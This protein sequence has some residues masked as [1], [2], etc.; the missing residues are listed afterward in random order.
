MIGLCTYAD[1]SFPG[2]MM[3]KTIPSLFISWGYSNPVTPV[4]GWPMH[5]T[6]FF[7]LIGQKNKIHFPDFLGVHLGC[8]SIVDLCV[9]QYLYRLEFNEIAWHRGKENAWYYL[10]GGATGKVSLSFSQVSL[11]NFAKWTRQTHLADYNHAISC[12]ISLTNFL[13]SWEETYN[14]LTE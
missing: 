9:L 1:Y 5:A 12:A 14:F 10:R 11:H 13:L 8:S 3:R 6:T 2:H 4:T 7:E